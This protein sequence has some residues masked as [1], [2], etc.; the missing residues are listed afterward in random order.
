MIVKRASRT[1]EYM[2]FFRAL[3]SV[4]PEERRLF[5][6]R[7]AERFVRSSLR[8]AVRASR[9]P[10]LARIVESYADWRLPGART[11]AISRTKMIDDA[12]REALRDGIR[13]VVILGAGF[14]CRAYRLSEMAG[15]KVYEVDHPA[16]LAV[17]REILSEALLEIPNSVRFVETDFNRRRLRE[18]LMEAG[19]ESQQPT[20]FLWEGVTNYL[21]RETV[22][23]VFG[24]VGNCGAGSRI[25]FT[26]VHKGLLDG[27]ARFEGGERILRDVERIGEPW[28]FGFVPEGLAE[29][30]KTRGVYLA[31]DFSAKGYRRIYWGEAARKMKGYEFYHVA[32]ADVGER[33]T[34]KGALGGVLV[35]RTHLWR[36]RR[37]LQEFFVAP[38]R[39]YE[40]WRM[41]D[42]RWG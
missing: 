18:V 36:V 14:D 37:T 40:R 10:M 35:R 32:I 2:A 24:Y 25:V 42:A 7:L 17:K 38:K 26:Y 33:K 39:K 30:L 9:W 23:D 41:F 20:M 5:V 19:F 22:D 12:V 1:A 15:A 3:E 29:Y 27:T 21:S 8:W 4:R 11:S 28:T 13:Q 34:R 31:R 6:D 16:T